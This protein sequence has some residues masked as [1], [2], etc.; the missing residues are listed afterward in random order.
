[1]LNTARAVQ[2]REEM[3]L[4]LAELG[5]LVGVDASTVYRW[6]AGE[7]EPRSEKLRDWARVLGIEVAELYADPDGPLPPDASA[8]TSR[9]VGRQPTGP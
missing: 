8:S 5:G 1:L 6:E 3:G 7:R 9:E 2:R 4:S